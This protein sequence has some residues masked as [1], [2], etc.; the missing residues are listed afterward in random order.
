MLTKAA[1]TKHSDE[2]CKNIHEFDCNE[3]DQNMN[4]IVVVCALHT[5]RVLSI[6]L[7]QTSRLQMLVKIIQFEALCLMK[8]VFNF[9]LS[10]Y[11]L[12]QQRLQQ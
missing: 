4:T 2:A 6:I 9:N 7:T 8:A 5:H 11:V 3:L 12:A 10:V 1:I